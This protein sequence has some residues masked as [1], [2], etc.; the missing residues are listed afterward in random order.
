MAGLNFN[1]GVHCITSEG[2]F[3]YYFK[4]SNFLS[5]I[6]SYR[7]NLSLALHKVL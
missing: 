7:T 4:A 2:P 5:R 3:W 1:S 6:Y